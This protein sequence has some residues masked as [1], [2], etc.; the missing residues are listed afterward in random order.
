[1]GTYIQVNSPAAI[2]FFCVLRAKFIDAYEFPSMYSQ[3][4]QN[5]KCLHYGTAIA[6]L[7]VKKSIAKSVFSFE[8]FLVANL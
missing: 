1:M 7:E 8:K 2:Y 3:N 6:D 5:N 4:E